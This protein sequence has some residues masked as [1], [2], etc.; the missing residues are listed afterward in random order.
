ML[1]CGPAPRAARGQASIA[2]LVER[3]WESDQTYVADHR[4]V[5]QTHDTALVIG[6]QM[7]NVARRGPGGWRYAIAL[8]GSFDNA[9]ERQEP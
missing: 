1:A 9:T 6:P 5:L 7:V 3:L 8:L 4:Q 2:A